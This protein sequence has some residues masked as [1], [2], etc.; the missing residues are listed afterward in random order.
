MLGRALCTL[1]VTLNSCT[2]KLA[3]LNVL[4]RRVFINQSSEHEI[5]IVSFEFERLFW[6]SCY[7]KM[8]IKTK[9]RQTII[10]KWNEQIR[11][12]IT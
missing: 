2:A 6:K 10:F 7:V 9:I 8:A 4:V 5:K 12:P 11:L 1:S 3:P